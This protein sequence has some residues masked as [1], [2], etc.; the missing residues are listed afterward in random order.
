MFLSF[1]NNKPSVEDV[2]TLQLLHIC[3]SCCANIAH[4]KRLYSFSLYWSVLR[5][6]PS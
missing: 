6:I 1:R 5:L 2:T 4:Q 3:I